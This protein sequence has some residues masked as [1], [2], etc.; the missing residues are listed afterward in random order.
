MVFLALF[1]SFLAFKNQQRS[2]KHHKV[3]IQHLN[4]VEIRVCAKQTQYE[5]VL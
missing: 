3:F 4:Y 1:R 5:L 2:I